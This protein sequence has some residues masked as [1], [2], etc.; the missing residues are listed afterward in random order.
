MVIYITHLI[1]TS[2]KSTIPKKSQTITAFHVNVNVKGFPVLQD[3][4]YK[5]I[6]RLRCQHYPHLV[7]YES[8]IIITAR[9]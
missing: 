2:M 5:I 3:T 1:V 6:R 4:A 7:S 9:A 8:F